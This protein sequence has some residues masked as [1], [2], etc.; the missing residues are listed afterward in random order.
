MRQLCSQCGVATHRVTDYMCD[1]P[2]S[3][4]YR[5]PIAETDVF[6]SNFVFWQTVSI[7]R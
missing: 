3:P 7:F 5:A 2:D 4:L 1:A 6:V